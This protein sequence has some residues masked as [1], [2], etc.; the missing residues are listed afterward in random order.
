MSQTITSSKTL[1]DYEREHRALA[2]R[3]SKT[4]FLWAG[5]INHR[6]LK[7]GNPRC[8]CRKDPDARHGPYIY[9][10]TKKAGKTISKRL[11]VDEA[12]VFEQWIA[13]RQELKQ[14]VDSMMAV[15]EQAIDLILEQKKRRTQP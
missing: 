10:S 8:A 1:E 6:Y 4:G 14:I 7:C 13:N 2:E 15:S 5:S 3:L 9:W 11:S 12:Q